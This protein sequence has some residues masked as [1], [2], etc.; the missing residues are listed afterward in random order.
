MNRA[1]TKLGFR[2][3]PVRCFENDTKYK[4]AT[5]IV[6][7]LFV[8]VLFVV[9]NYVQYDQDVG[10]TKNAA[11][12]YQIILKTNDANVTANNNMNHDH[13]I[14]IQ[15]D[16]DTKQQLLDADSSYGAFVGT[17]SEKG[18]LSTSG[19]S[20]TTTAADNQAS[21]ISNIR[22]EFC[23]VRL[24]RRMHRTIVSHFFSPFFQYT[25]C[26]C[27]PWRLPFDQL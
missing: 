14:V 19:L 26:C 3:S 13:G 7:L 17:R 27:R 22:P 25:L 8:S 2:R 23:E 6:C 18:D 12:G 20:A 24:F 5:L 1:K 11:Q 15:Q 16:K 9:W 10:H 21:T 4:K